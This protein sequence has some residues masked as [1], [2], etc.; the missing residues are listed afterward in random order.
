[1]SAVPVAA[2]Y[3]RTVLPLVVLLIAS[4]TTARVARA[5]ADDVK[6]PAKYVRFTDEKGGGRLETAVVTYKNDAGVELK[7]V[8]AI[9]IGERSYFESLNKDFEADDAVLY[10]LVKEKGQPLPGPEAM[11]RKAAEGG[12]GESNPIGQL[13]RFL[14]DTL[15]LEFQ[16]DVVDY[17]KKNFV[18]ADMDR[19]AFEKAQAER[20]ESFEMMMLQQLL[21]AMRNPQAHG[22]PGG[23]DAAAEDPEK[24]LKE[25][26]KIVT[27]PD[28]DRQVK[29]YIAK[30]MDQMQDAA[31]GL[32]GPG[33]SV[34]LT[35]RNKAAVKVLEDTVKA[36]KKKISI[37]Y[38]AAHMPDLAKR[39]RAMGFKPSG[40]VEWKA[41]WDLRI[42]A[43]QPSAVE[44]LL[45]DFIDALDEPDQAPANPDGVF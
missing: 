31:M 43:D 28:M 24:M 2:S 27:R 3:R 22:L 37:F 10:E 19:A 30:Q 23:A 9:H 45:N 13:Q 14:K 36:G 18:H 8:S 38:G 34:I 1:M 6:E 29:T 32:D 17:S 11:R 39:V 25:L 42:R 41:A 20:G 7:L 33:G 15:A 12:G 26:V 40:E 44:K 21:A 16:L 5:A 35:E 4:A